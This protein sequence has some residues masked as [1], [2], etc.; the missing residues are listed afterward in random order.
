ML[1]TASAERA[2]RSDFLCKRRHRDL[3][4]SIDKV[5][6]KTTAGTFTLLPGPERPSYPSYLHQLVDR[7]DTATFLL[8]GGL[9][10]NRHISDKIQKL[11]P[12]IKAKS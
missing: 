10:K 4:K 6:A 7:W 8:A 2:Q 5:S 12:I 1:P 3:M 11:P 9:M